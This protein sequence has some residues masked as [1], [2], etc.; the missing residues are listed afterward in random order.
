M[1]VGKQRIKSR[2]DEVLKRMTL[3]KMNKLVV[4]KGRRM[5]PLTAADDTRIIDLL[6]CSIDSNLAG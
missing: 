2:S 3:C 6:Y 5:L 4:E 1:N